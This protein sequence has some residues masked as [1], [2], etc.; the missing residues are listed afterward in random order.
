M[1]MGISEIQNAAVTK[2][3][4]G[5][6]ISLVK[7]DI[8]DYDIECFVYYASSDLK[9][10]AGFGGA[11]AVRGGPQIQKDL[12]KMAPVEPYRAVISDAGEL[13]AK[14]IIHANGPKFQEEDMEEKIKTTIV[15]SLKLA[16]E[17]GIKR[18]AFPPMGTGFYGVTLDQSARVTLHSIKEYL[19]GNTGIEEVTVCLN[20]NREFQPFKAHFDKL[21]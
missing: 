8:T 11:I 2:N 4:G 13:K 12:D 17:K 15:N 16:D 7:T 10:G 18:I 21:G 1:M 20:D 19:Q 3:I 6:V 5:K 9:L 14:Y